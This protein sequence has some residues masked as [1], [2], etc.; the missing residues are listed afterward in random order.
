MKDAMNLNKSLFYV[1]IVSSRV[2]L[3]E[4]N[5]IMYLLINLLMFIFNIIVAI[6]TNYW[7]STI[8]FLILGICTIKEYK[9][10][11][12]LCIILAIVV[13]VNGIL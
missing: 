5:I 1:I 8:V 10:P 4:R 6:F 2:L 13:F 3:N 11:G 9:G 7:I 12:I